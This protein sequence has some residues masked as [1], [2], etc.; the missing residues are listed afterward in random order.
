V[1]GTVTLAV[2]ATDDGSVA[3]V[4]FMIDG[5]NV[6]GEDTTAPYAFT[7]DTLT[8]ANGEHTVSA[9]ARDAAGNSATATTV[10]VTVANDTTAPA[11]AVTSPAAASTVTGTVTLAVSATDDGSVAGVQFTIDGANVGAEDTTAPYELAW[12][13]LTAANGVHTITAVARDT[14]GNQA[15]ATSVSVTVANDTTAPTVA[16]TSPDAET[17]V[18]GIVT[19][20]AAVADDVG[21]VSVV[22]LLDGA[23][24]GAPDLVAPYELPWVTAT[25][26]SGPHTLTVIARD[27]AGNQTTA[28][29]PITV[30]N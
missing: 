21:V 22:F 16:L 12:D 18:T 27:A 26:E 28:S 15:T 25:A 19:V 20:T 23:P 6:G 2:S 1:T 3:G 29:A 17:A 10:S 5:A 11:V 7:W 13:T 30:T 14:A 9:V 24:L 8:A 4:Q